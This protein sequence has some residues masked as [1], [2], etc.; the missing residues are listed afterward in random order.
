MVQLLPYHKLGVSKHQR[1][2]KKE[3]IFVAEPPSDKLMQARKAQL[4]EY[5]LNVTIH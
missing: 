1:L 5:G 4:E 3:K 2:M